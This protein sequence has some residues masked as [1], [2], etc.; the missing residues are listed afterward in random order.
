M[1]AVGKKMSGRLRF[2]P[3]PLGP[4]AASDLLAEQKIKQTDEISRRYRSTRN[5]IISIA[6]FAL[7]IAIAFAV[8]AGL[9]Y[10]DVRN[11]SNPIAL[12]VNQQ[13]PASP[14]VFHVGGS[15]LPVALTLP[16]DLT[17]YIGKIYRLW[18]VSPQV[19][20]LTIQGTGTTFDGVN[21]VATWGG[22]I[23]D[24]VMFEVLQANRIVLISV[25][26][27]NFS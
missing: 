24:G 25:N 19:H 27:V 13:M 4:K 8:L 1:L 12:Y 6:A 7:V 20:T 16:N 5:I 3:P 14:F 11:Y 23:G 15:A 10:G 26:N 21:K 22:A 17:P 9:A 2:Q 18:S